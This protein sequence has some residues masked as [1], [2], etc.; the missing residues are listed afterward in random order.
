[1]V[2]SVLCSI[3]V[4]WAQIF[5]L[6]R[7][8]LHDIEKI[9]KSYL[10]TGEY[11]SSKGGYV[12]WPKVCIPKYAGGLGIRNITKWNVA[13]MGRYT[14]AISG[15]KDNLWIHWINDVYIKDQEWWAYKPPMDS[16]WYWKKACEVKENLKGVVNEAQLMTLNQYSV[17]RIYTLLDGDY[18]KVHWDKFI[19]C[20]LVIPKHRLILWLVMHNRLHTGDRLQRMG[21]RQSSSC[22]I[23]G[24]GNET[25]D[26]L[27]FSC[28]FS[29][30]VLQEIGIWLGWSITNMIVQSMIQ[31]LARSRVSKFTKQAY[32]MSIAA[33]VYHI[34]WAS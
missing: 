33:M 13:V 18:E 10:W 30:V 15:K 24:L 28:C 21:V 32:A 11:F 20:R 17:K 25:Q 23:C 8:V 27:F 14:W 34:W 31:R 16:S 1:M 3:H 26:H 4:Y 7:K 5:V 9:S 22:L 2:N 12:A 29:S 19:W 6:P